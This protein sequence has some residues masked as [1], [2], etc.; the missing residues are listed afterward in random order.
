MKNTRFKTALISLGIFTIAASSTVA[1]TQNSALAQSSTVTMQET[2]IYAQKQTD[3][4]QDH[5]QD[6]F[7]MELDYYLEDYKEG[8]RDG[9]IDGFKAALET[10]CQKV[11]CLKMPILLLMKMV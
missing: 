11:L 3:D 8:Y 4:F 7:D 6:D 2:P 1:F 5:Y 10:I 9:F